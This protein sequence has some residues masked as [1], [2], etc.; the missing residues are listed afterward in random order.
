[1][2]LMDLLAGSRVELCGNGLVFTDAET[3]RR[4]APS[5]RVNQPQFGYHNTFAAGGTG[6]WPDGS[7]IDTGYLCYPAYVGDGEIIATL[8][9]YKPLQFPRVHPVQNPGEHALFLT[10]ERDQPAP[11]PKPT[12]AQVLAVKASYCS[13]KDDS[14]LVMF[15]AFAPSLWLTNRPK[16]NEWIAKAKLLGTH[17]VVAFQSNDYKLGPT[18]FYPV[19]GF[20]FDSNPAEFCKMLDAILDAG[21][22]PVVFLTS[23]DSPAER[24]HVTPRANALKAYANWCVWFHGWETIGSQNPTYTSRQWFDSQNEMRAVFGPTAVLGMHVDPAERCTW[25]SA[26]GYNQSQPVEGCFWSGSAWVENDDPSG[27]D[28]IGAM[29]MLQIDV[30]A[31]QTRH[32]GGG[33]SGT[34]G[35]LNDDTT[36]SGHLVEIA[37]RFLPPGSMIPGLNR[38]VQGPDWFSGANVTR[39]VFCAFETVCVEYIRGQCSEQQ[40]KDASW[41]CRAAGVLSEGCRR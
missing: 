15:T 12:R 14:G 32:G 27:G 34:M 20:N 11:A 24:V 21:L 10:M 4:I 8:P 26:R 36:W 31:I 17:F 41:T 5:V 1:M 19:P 3:G 40:A 18:E 25:A 16:F 6:T 7:P 2:K 33:P 30:Y 13:A 9:G 37:D 35:D 39:P 22:V 23:G 28:E 38:V 29:R